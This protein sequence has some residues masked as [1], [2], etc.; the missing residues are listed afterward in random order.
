MKI[1][2]LEKVHAFSLA[3]D[4]EMRSDFVHVVDLLVIHGY[5][6]RLPHSKYVTRN[7]FELRTFGRREIRILYT[8]YKSQAYMLHVFIKKQNK[9]PMY[10]FDSVRKDYFKDR[11][12]RNAWNES[13]PYYDMV[14]ALIDARNR[15][16][17]T[18]AELAR[19]LKTKQSAISR[20]ESG[21]VKNPTISSLF[22]MAKALGVQIAL[23]V[24]PLPKKV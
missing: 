22:D 4:S 2:I 24:E 18:Q 21:R 17:I 13:R 11:G 1:I 16:N 20:F 6:L 23:S 5:D 7:I 9:I 12:F 8:F 19:R 14:S 3:L 15:G 10:D